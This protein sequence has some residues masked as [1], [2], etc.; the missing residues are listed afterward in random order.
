MIFS[1]DGL[2]QTFLVAF[3]LWAF[4]SHHSSDAVLLFNASWF[5]S[6]FLF[7]SVL[8]DR[9]MCSRSKENAPNMV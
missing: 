1:S 8:G 5:G 4:A 3:W 7:F 9:A 6:A 2:W